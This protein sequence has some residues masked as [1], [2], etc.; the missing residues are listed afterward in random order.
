M[1]QLR[2]IYQIALR[3][4][5]ILR[6][7]PMYLFCMVIFPVVVM[8]F[9]TTLMAEGQPSNMPVGVVD[10]DNT[11]ETRQLLRLLDAFQNTEL[12][13]QYPNVA[14]ARKAIQRNEIYAFVYVPK[15]TSGGLIGNS[16]PT[17]SFYYSLSSVTAGSL[18]YKNLKTI[19]SLGSA[20]MIRATMRAK[21]YT[22]KQILNFIQPIRVDL[23]QVVNPMTDYNVYLSTML[24]PGVFMMFIFLI[25]A[26]SLGTELKFNRAKEWMQMADG[27]TWVAIVGK[28][29]PQTLIFL[30]LMYA[31]WLY[32]FGMMGFPHRG[33]MGMILLLGLLSVLASQGFGIFV[34]GLMPSL[35]MS[36]SICSLWS[37]LSFSMVGSA[38]PIVAMDAPLQAL[39]ALFPLRHVF[40]T[41]QIVVFNGYPFVNA[42]PYVLAL[43]AFALLGTIVLPKVKNAMLTYVYIP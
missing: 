16:Q 1:K 28:F 14:E 43:I 19:S 24:V 27:N 30:T 35:R 2:Q 7:N 6:Q 10:Q 37:V 18:L 5:G 13:R 20:A 39:A 29:L 3:E 36:M 23:H 9:F 4:C 38:F 41:Y 15:G 21:G 25:T 26:Y 17:I 34:F 8:L 33:S 11:P 31:F 32:A 12:V 42:W 22:D 40:M